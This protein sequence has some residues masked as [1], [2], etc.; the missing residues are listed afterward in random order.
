MGC[1]AEIILKT[2]STLKYGELLSIEINVRYFLGEKNKHVLL[3]VLDIIMIGNNLRNA[4]KNIG[5]LTQ[6]CKTTIFQ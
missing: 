1:Q 2:K 3:N 5:I 6:Y 4:Y